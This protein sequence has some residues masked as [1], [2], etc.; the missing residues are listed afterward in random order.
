MSMF[1]LY[2]CVC[3][4]FKNDNKTKYNT[5]LLTNKHKKNTTHIIPEKEDNICVCGK[6]F[7][8]KQGL[9][10][11]KSSCKKTNTDNNEVIS[12]LLKQNEEY[13][14]IIIEKTQEII[15][16]NKKMIE[17]ASRP[18]VINNITNNFNLNVFLSDADRGRLNII[19][20]IYNIGIS[21]E[22]FT[23]ILNTGAVYNEINND[24]LAQIVHCYGNKDD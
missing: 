20:Y 11:H 1:D 14:K 12:L 16:Q 18:N 4:N 8:Y 7:K 17:L 2:S 21:L 9:L 15:N 13:K 3:C 6:I 5:H 24:A 10:R 23:N 22:D 19:D